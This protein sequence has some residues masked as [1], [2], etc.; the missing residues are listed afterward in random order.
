MAYKKKGPQL[1]YEESQCWHMKKELE[2]F[3]KTRRHFNGKVRKSYNYVINSQWAFLLPELN[4]SAIAK[5]Y[6]KSGHPFTSIKSELIH[7][8]I[9]ERL[10]NRLEEVK[11]VAASSTLGKSLLNNTCFTITNPTIY[12]FYN[13]S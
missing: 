4:K 11:I 2:G 8:A 3:L 7:K 5:H 13:E 6:L 10:L 9:K 12:K 1:A